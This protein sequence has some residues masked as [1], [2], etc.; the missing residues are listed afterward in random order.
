VYAFIDSITPASNHGL[1]DVED[2]MGVT[3]AEML[4]SEAIDLAKILASNFRF[5][6]ARLVYMYERSNED[7]RGKCL[8][9]LNQHD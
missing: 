4:T 7:V 5:A 2:M 3:L 1:L 6:M 8:H 9:I